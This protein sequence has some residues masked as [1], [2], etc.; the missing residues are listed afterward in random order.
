M[1]SAV[2][3]EMT[4]HREIRTVREETRAETFVRAASE[5]RAEKTAAEPLLPEAMQLMAAE[6]DRAG[7]RATAAILRADARAVQAQV[8]QLRHLM[9][10]PRTAEEAAEQAPAEMIIPRIGRINL[11][12]IRTLRLRRRERAHLLS[13]SLRRKHPRMRL[14]R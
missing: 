3:A 5:E 8:W 11:S 13:L 6:P 12:I 2:T 14:S 9:E 4:E 10:H 7:Y 1:P